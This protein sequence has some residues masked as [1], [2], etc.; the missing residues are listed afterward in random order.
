MVHKQ[1]P[2]LNVSFA[3]FDRSMKESVVVKLSG[4]SEECNER[5]LKFALKRVAGIRFVGYSESDETD[6]ALYVRCEEPADALKVKDY[7]NDLKA[8]FDKLHGDNAATD[9]LK[10]QLSPAEKEVV[11]TLGGSVPSAV[12]LQGEEEKKYWKEALDNMQEAVRNRVLTKMHRQKMRG[13]REKRKTDEISGSAEDGD[14]KKT[15]TA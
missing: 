7:I 10:E 11:Q 14:S 4:A 15:R 3:Q 2:T 1:Q 8:K 6:D 9:G 5:A 12:I 13:R